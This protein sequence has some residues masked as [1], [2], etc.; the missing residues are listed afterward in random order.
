M[1]QQMTDRWIEAAEARRVCEWAMAEQP[2][3]SVSVP[4]PWLIAK[5]S[6]LLKVELAQLRLAL[7]PSAR[8]AA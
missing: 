7:I 3:R 2:V 8:P 1:R 6:D 5:L 4:A